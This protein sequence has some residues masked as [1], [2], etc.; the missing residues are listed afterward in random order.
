[1]TSC[2]NRRF[3]GDVLGVIATDEEI[4]ALLPVVEANSDHTSESLRPADFKL[5]TIQLS[6][7]SPIA[8]RSITDIQLGKRYKALLVS[9]DRDG[10]FITPGPHTIFYPHDVL[11]MVGNPNTLSELK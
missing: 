11:W 5:T 1:M 4:Q 6:D 10:E 2:D 7:T 3:P 9:I 8:G